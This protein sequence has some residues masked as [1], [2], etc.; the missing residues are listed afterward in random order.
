MYCLYVS[1]ETSLCSSFIFT[2]VTLIPHSFMYG[3]YV[4]G[5]ITLFSSFIFT[6]FTS[7]PHSFMDWLY[8]SGENILPSSFIFTL[9]TSIPHSFMYRLYVSGEITLISSFVFTL[10]TSIPDSFILAVHSLYNSTAVPAGWEVK[11]CR[12]WSYGTACKMYTDR[13][14]RSRHGGPKG[15]IQPS[16]GA[17]RRRG[18]IRCQS[19]YFL[20]V[21]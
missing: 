5:E 13:K 10:I 17:R 15:P 4:N 18:H 16:A 19:V 11:T 21:W 7:V 3:I 2:L 9:I 12:N 20:T 14:H 8:V 1:G 6:L